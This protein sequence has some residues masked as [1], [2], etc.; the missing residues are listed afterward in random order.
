MALDHLLLLPTSEH[1]QA[2]DEFAMAFCTA[3][4]V[5]KSNRLILKNELEL[6]E[7]LPFDIE[8]VGLYESRFANPI[9]RILSVP[10]FSTLFGHLKMRPDS[11]C[12][13]LM[14]EESLER[15]AQA[16]I[17]SCSK[18]TLSPVHSELV[19][20]WIA[21]YPDG[22]TV[23]LDMTPLLKRLDSNMVDMILQQILADDQDDYT[24][25]R[26]SLITRDIQCY[27]SPSLSSKLCKYIIDLVNHG[28]SHTDKKNLKECLPNLGKRLD[29]K[30]LLL[31]KKIWP[32]DALYYSDLSKPLISLR[33][34][35]EARYE[36]FLYISGS[37]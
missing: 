19:T 36:L 27:L 16:A 8:T 32:D 18:S 6:P 14:M 9:Y 33:E 31:L 10:T 2:V 12:Q 29:P 26:M 37:K 24:I 30:S 22:N 23:P 13:Q 28:C 11:V 17:Y 7:A 4:L 35:L 3:N 15:M 20:D 25:E 1:R 21:L 5:L 34:T